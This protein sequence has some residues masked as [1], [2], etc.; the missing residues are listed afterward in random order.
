MKHIGIYIHIPFCKSKCIYCDFYSVTDASYVS[1][2]VDAVIKQIKRFKKRNGIVTVHSIY[3]GGGTPS[4]I[5]S[6]YIE[7]ILKTI[8]SL[9][10]VTQNCE[11]SIEANPG[12]LTS[13]KLSSYK[14][15]GINRISI[16]LQSCHNSEL[17][18]LSRIHTKEEFEQAFVMCRI[19]GFDNINVDLM[20]GLPY[21]T[22]SLLKESVEYVTSLKP[23]HISLYCLKV[24]SETPLAKM[25]DLLKN[26]PSEETQCDMFMEARDYLEKLGYEQYEI[27]NFAKPGKECKHNLTYWHS[28]NYVGFGCAAAS[29]FNGELYSYVKDIETVIAYPTDSVRCICES[30]ILSKKEQAKQYLMLAFRLNEGI[31]TNEYTTRFGLNFEEEYLPLMKKYIDNGFIIKTLKGYRLSKDGLLISNFI[32][33]DILDFTKKE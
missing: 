3:F 17:S 25:S 31:D 18:M 22:S 26:I 2:Y 1:D 16:G 33:S 23:D 7:T 28:K 32:L 15:M 9:F 20:Y 10:I 13:S 5:D 11:I 19:E 29:F 4:I 27:S 8:R 30:E 14:H 24:E 6:S 21:Q 12:T